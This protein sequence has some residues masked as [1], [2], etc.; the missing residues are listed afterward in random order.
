VGHTLGWSEPPKAF[1]TDDDFTYFFP[2]KA[3]NFISANI[4]RKIVCHPT[5]HLTN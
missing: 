3:E 1:N 5:N 4:H 2:R